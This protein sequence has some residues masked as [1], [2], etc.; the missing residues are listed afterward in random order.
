MIGSISQWLRDGDELRAAELVEQCEIDTHYI[1]TCFELEGERSW[2]LFDV[3]IAAPRRVHK[4]IEVDAEA[5]AQIESAIRGQGES[6]GVYVRDI[7]WVPRMTTATD[8]KD[9]ELDGVLTSFD[10]EHV[11]R[12][13]RKSLARKSTDPDGAI[14]AA[15][16]LLES[17]CKHVLTSEGVVFDPT[18]NLPNL[19]HSA[20]DAIN[21]SPRQQTDQTLRQVM[22]NC[23]AIVNGIASIRNDIGDAHGKAEG[24][25]IA[26]SVH[27]EFVVN[28]AA[29]VAML[30]LSRF[31][32]ANTSPAG[33]SFVG[34]VKP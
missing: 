15:R 1:D 11:T 21:L 23:Q 30:V 6:D 19:F 17:V 12:F 27:A 33:G 16:S 32:S 14:T 29:S 4:T 8:R 34:P 26:D 2:N 25:L 31:D 5:C 7:R 9:H 22:G 3:S 28:L 20:L 13:W 24:E 10:A 18:V